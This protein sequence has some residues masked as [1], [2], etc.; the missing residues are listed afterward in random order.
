MATGPTAF[1]DKTI[2]DGVF[3]PDIWSKYLIKS[4]TKNLVFADAVMTKFE[5]VGKIGK[6][7]FFPTVGLLGSR[8]KTE[9]AAIDY[10]DIDETTKSITMNQVYYAA[11][12]IEYPVDVQSMIDLE[13]VYMQRV[14]YALELRFDSAIAALVAG[15]SQTVGTLAQD[16]TNDHI[17]DAIEYLDVANVPA[18]DRCFIF[19]AEAK[20]N[21]RK[22][23]QYVNADYVNGKPTSNG[24]LGELWGIRTKVTTNTKANSGGH[25]NVLL[26]KESIGAVMQDRS[27]PFELMDPDYLTKKIAVAMVYGVG[28]LR[29][30]HGVWI[31]GR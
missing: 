2:A 4:R 3:N 25:D 19:S 12:G 13:P 16:N 8:A 20:K 29:D 9:N 14:A 15:F 28:E 23:D 30:D 17:L 27:A 5:G 6:R 7:V 26:H 21:L 1:F 11:F 10:E 18:E 22:I 24:N 31:K